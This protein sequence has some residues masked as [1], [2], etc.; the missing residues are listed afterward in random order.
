MSNIHTSKLVIFYPQIK[1]LLKEEKS[2]DEVLN[3][4]NNNLD[5][6]ITKKQLEKVIYNNH[7]LP[8][9]NDYIR[10]KFK[11]K[12]LEALRLIQEEGYSC[13]KAAKFLHMDQQ[14]MNSRLK[15]YY[16]FTVL[17]DGK[18]EVNSN[19]FD[20]IDTEEK[21]YWLGFFFADGYVSSTKKSIELCI[22]E[23]DKSHISKFKKAINSKHKISSKKIKFDGK[24]FMASRISIK[25][26]K[27]WKDLVKHGCI[28]VKS[29]TI[30][31]P[32]L[33]SKELYR[34]FFRGYF[35]GDGSIQRGNNRN[36]VYVC[37]CITSGSLDFLKSIQLYCK[38]L[39]IRTTLRYPSKNHS[40]YDLRT[41]SRNEAITFLNHLYENSTIYL[42]RKYNQYQEICRLENI[43]QDSLEDESGI[44]QGWRKVS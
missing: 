20:V 34:H 19:Y 12:D 38:D 40:A 30:E 39:G 26:E 17:P 4:I 11:E 33:D 6:P 10:E 21:A 44:K 3:W 8:T 36:T 13:T 16:G 24:E 1:E 18:K 35:D 23:Y 25:D 29:K 27:I 37:A 2:I 9:S 41:T 28:P 43:L 14:S 22:Q 15:K 31:L 42:D 5:E 7:L 32:S